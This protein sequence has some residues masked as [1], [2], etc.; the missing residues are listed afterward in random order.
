MDKEDLRKVIEDAVKKAVKDKTGELPEGMHIKEMRFDSRE[1]LENFL[2]NL[3]NI[4]KI[5]PEKLKEEFEVEM[6]SFMNGFVQKMPK[7]T[8]QLYEWAEN[9]MDD[10]FEELNKSG[11]DSIQIVGM[12]EQLKLRWT[13]KFENMRKLKSGVKEAIGKSKPKSKRG[14][15]KK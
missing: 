15:S 2:S 3:H 12:L 8:L 11:L 6:E 14:K 7:N 5:D 9:W 4:P 10:T 1:E 13:C